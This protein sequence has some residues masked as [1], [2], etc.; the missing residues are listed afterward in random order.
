MG[1]GEKVVCIERDFFNAIE[2]GQEYLI[3]GSSHGKDTLYFELSGL[4]NR[5]FSSENFITL[6]E[7]RKMKLL[8][9]KERIN[10]S[11]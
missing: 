9:L 8:K 4:R 11:R 6:V 3:T 2:V 1:V 5:F 10:G 7:Y